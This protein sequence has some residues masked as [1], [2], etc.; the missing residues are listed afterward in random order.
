L[1][2]F[3]VKLQNPNKERRK[4]SSKSYFVGLTDIKLNSKDPHLKKTLHNILVKIGK[5]H[6]NS[7]DKQLQ[8][9]VEVLS[10]DIN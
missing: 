6:P 4:E 9:H 5:N 7:R 2:K 10:S 3:S 1:K 8:S